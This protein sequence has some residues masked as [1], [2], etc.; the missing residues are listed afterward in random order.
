MLTQLAQLSLRK[1]LPLLLGLFAL[2]FTL[3]LTT[4]YLPR[5]IDKELHAWRSHTNQLLVLLQST[6]SN[7]LRHGRQAELETALADFASL[8]GVRWAMVADPQLRVLAATRLGLAPGSS[9]SLPSGCRHSWPAGIPPG[10]STPASAIW[11]SSRST[12]SASAMARV[13]RRCWSIWTSARCSAR[14]ASK[15]GSTSARSSCCCCSGW[16][17]TASTTA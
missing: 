14:P 17:S 6:L 8:R 5:S 7:H 12:R 15:P 3:L 4:L 1:S 16:P 2:L 13:A 9:A 10:W 11:P